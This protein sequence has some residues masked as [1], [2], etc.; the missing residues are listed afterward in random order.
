[1]PKILLPCPKCGEEYKTPETLERHITRACLSVSASGSYAP[2][3][4]K[5]SP[6]IKSQS[7]EEGGIKTRT[8]TDTRVR[9]IGGYLVKGPAYRRVQR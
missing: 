9:M 5:S 2:S 7:L 4:L 8:D 6:D 3:W 1:M